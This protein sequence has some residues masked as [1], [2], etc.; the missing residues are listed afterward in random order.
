MAIWIECFENSEFELKLFNVAGIGIKGFQMTG[1][2]IAQAELDPTLVDLHASYR[3]RNLELV[4]WAEL[5]AS[6]TG[7][8]ITHCD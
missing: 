7:F 1:I 2:G 6:L 3:I 5:Y 4:Y 8:V